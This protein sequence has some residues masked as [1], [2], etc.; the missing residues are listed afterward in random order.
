MRFK[1]KQDH[2]QLRQ[3][4][5]PPEV[6]QLGAFAKALRPIIEAL[7]PEVRAAIPPDALAVLDQIEAVKTKFP[8]SGRRR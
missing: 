3:G 2:G 5:Y 1:L 4:E 7:P 8:K 6:E